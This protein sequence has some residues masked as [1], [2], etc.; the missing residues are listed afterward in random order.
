MLGLTALCG[1]VA[2]KAQAPESER[3]I[4]EMRS[5][6]PQPYISPERKAQMLTERMDSLLG[7]DK[8]SIKNCTKSIS[9]RRADR[10][11][12]PSR[13]PSAWADI[14]ARVADGRREATAWD[15]AVPAA[16]GHRTISTAIMA[17]RN[18]NADSRPKI[19]RK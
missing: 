9:K 5:R 12:M 2:A 11:K 10:P 8:N 4:R 14:R 6:D 18:T 1:T 13:V 15:R 3:I 17:V 7:L 16:D 19:W